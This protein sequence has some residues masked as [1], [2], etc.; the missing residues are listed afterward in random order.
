MTT[1]SIFDWNGKLLEDVRE[2]EKTF[3]VKLEHRPGEGTMGFEVFE[4]SG[5]GVARFLGHYSLELDD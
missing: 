3:D 1:I 5:S 4:I 2:D